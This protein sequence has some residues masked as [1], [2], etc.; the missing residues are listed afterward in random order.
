MDEERSFTRQEKPRQ[1]NSLDMN[2]MP[3]TMIGDSGPRQMPNRALSATKDMV[4]EATS[5]DLGNEP[6]PRLPAAK[7]MRGRV[8]A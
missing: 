6:L 7:P 3:P 2:G 4:A 5:L 1:R 8:Y